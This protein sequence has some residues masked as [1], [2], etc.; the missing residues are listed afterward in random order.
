M[1]LPPH[2]ILI[3]ADSFKGSLASTDVAR[4]A[5]EGVRQALPHCAAVEI[6]VADG[7]EGFTEALIPGEELAAR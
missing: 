2:K 4:A 6:P 7:G 3:A 1:C 5:A